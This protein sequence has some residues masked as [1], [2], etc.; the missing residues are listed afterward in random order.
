MQINS[1]LSPTS[2]NYIADG[3]AVVVFLILS[4]KAMK[5]G[6][7]GCLFGFVSTVISLIVAVAFS[8][9]LV[10]A[11]G[12]LFGLLEKLPHEVM[13]SFVAGLILFF[14]CKLVIGLVKKILSSVIDKIPIVGAL[15]HGLGFL[16][17]AVEGFF[18]IC[19]ILALLALLPISG[20]HE[21]FYDCTVLKFLYHDN[22][23][24]AIL[25]WVGGFSSSS[26]L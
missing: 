9:Q 22:P 14:V 15:N 3:V 8:G 16:V 10:A 13:A 17:G 1:I 18:L 25:E 23:I 20:I 5:K 26:I 19:G 24:Y 12:G 2:A 21:F 11:T 4:L 7:V 6:F